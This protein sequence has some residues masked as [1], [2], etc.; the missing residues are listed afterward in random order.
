MKI[1]TGTM[2]QMRENSYDDIRNGVVN[3]GGEN[4]SLT[5]NN[6]SEKKIEARA[7]SSPTKNAIDPRA[8]MPDEYLDDEYN[9]WS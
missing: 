1:K 4:S 7:A 8:N 6:N 5:H 9:S 3:R 2:I